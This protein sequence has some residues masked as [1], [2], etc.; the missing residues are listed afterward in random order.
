M[1]A[2]LK[3][4]R[5]I[6]SAALEMQ[7]P[8]DRIDFLNKSCADS[9][10]LRDR[11]QGLLNA[12]SEAGDFL[13]YRVDLGESMEAQS[14]WIGRYKLIEKIGEGGCGVV[15]RAEQQ[16]PLQ[17][18]VALKVIKSG[19]DT[20]SVIARFE[21]ERQALAL[22]DHPHIAKV[23]DAGA[24][25]AGRP[26]FL[27]ELVEG[28]KITEYATERQLS[29]RERLVLFLQVCDA[30]QH[31]HLKGIIHRDL[32][33]S[34][35]LVAHRNKVPFAQIIDFGIAK[36]IQGRLTAETIVTSVDQFMGTPAYMSPE[37]ALITS[38][39]I[40][41]RSDIYS[42]GVLLYEL[43]A[44]KPPFDSHELLTAGLDEMRRIIREVDPIYPSHFSEASGAT[45][46]DRDLDCI[47]MKCLEK[48]RSRRYQVASAL[49][50]D[51][52]RY[53]HDEPI[54]A[55][56]ASAAYR[57]RKLIRRHRAGSLAIVGITLAVVAGA[58]ISTRAMI[59][60]RA[61]RMRQ[62]AAL[63]ESNQRL[64]A[65]LGFVDNILTNVAPELRLV[66]GAAKAQDKLL[67]AGLNFVKE[68]REGAADHPSARVALARL[69]LYISERENPG[70]P[71]SLGD[72][73][74][75][76]E[77]AE[78]ALQLIGKEKSS[79]NE[80]ERLQLLWQGKV[81][82]IQC[83]F[84][85]G[86]FDEGITRSSDCETIL[87]QLE[88]YPARAREARRNRMLVRANM[89]W[90]AYLAGRP[91]EALHKYLLPLLD[92]EWAHSI[93]D[94][95]DEDELH[96]VF[97]AHDNAASAFA[98]L[99]DF[100]GML[101]HAKEASR[102]ASLSGERSPLNLFYI[103]AIPQSLAWEGYGLIGSGD[104]LNGLVKLNNAR[105]R[106]ENRPASET[107]TEA[108]QRNRVIIISVQAL[109]HA[110]WSFDR[111]AS[112]IVRRERFA[113]AELYLA[114]AE[115]FSRPLKSPAQAFVAAR[116]EIRRARE[117]FNPDHKGNSSP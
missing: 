102:I 72:Y 8:A 37:Q 27:M 91:H 50:A 48:E 117:I 85:L 22:M 33:P 98:V 69:L 94:R 41:T 6:F 51:I 52:V 43:L 24:T 21:A 25:E 113:Q 99:K 12:H 116:A 57:F 74:A 65:A 82:I 109:A 32:K 81:A 112:E 101:P 59:A 36:A 16:E 97:I 28:A 93:T 114:E 11:L 1:K 83:L 29:T 64:A 55:R 3:T 61:A 39:D 30:V 23:F 92:G 80:E 10:E 2:D 5:E 86:R 62:S 100:K 53:L 9:V 20:R 31:A 26:Y 47:V 54:T 105:E 78:E 75:A 90:A 76:L 63:K 49:S 18:T 79:M 87:N 13:N 103:Y 66:A 17:R 107:L 35:I 70:E 4:V 7:S 19:M 104:A 106:I 110:V 89:G 40:D 115:A 58:V 77:R 60:E 14:Q 111:S 68:L 73:S 84:G 56:S 15:Y 71:N 38:E 45:R 95:S 42:L 108:F 88:L 44:G 46:I 96:V 34:N 67:K